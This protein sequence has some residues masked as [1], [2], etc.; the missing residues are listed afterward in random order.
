MRR[1]FGPTWLCF[2]PSACAP[3][4]LELTLTRGTS[5]ASISAVTDARAGPRHYGQRVKKGG[6]SITPAPGTSTSTGVAA[7]ARNA[8]KERALPDRREL[9]ALAA[10]LAATVLTASAAIAGLTRKAA[11]RRSRRPPTVEP[12]HRAGARP[13]A[14]ESSRETDAHRLGNRAL[15]LGALRRRRVPRL[16]APAADAARSPQSVPGAVIVKGKNGTSRL[17]VV[18]GTGTAAPHATTRTSP[19]PAG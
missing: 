3:G 16:D 6:A 13:A 10:V 5:A 18:S 2:R 17:V 9:F 7:A 19:V 4:R 12:D 11:P 8:G 1:Q 15:R 14:A